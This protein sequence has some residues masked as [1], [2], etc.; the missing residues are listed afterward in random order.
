MAG[1]FDAA[2]FAAGGVGFACVRS[3]SGKDGRVVDGRVGVSAALAGGGKK[4]G[5]G[6]TECFWQFAIN[7]IQ[8]AGSSDLP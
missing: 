4:A 3:P 6:L 8:K 1:A 7:R 2:L 5:N